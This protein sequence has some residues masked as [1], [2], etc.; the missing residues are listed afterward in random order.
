MLFWLGYC[1][2]CGY[3]CYCGYYCRYSVVGVFVIMTVIVMIIGSNSHG[4]GDDNCGSSSHGGGDCVV[5]SLPCVA[6]PAPP[7]A[8]RRSPWRP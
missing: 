4:G 8:C 7:G 2:D 1:C 5:I 6:P 3:Y